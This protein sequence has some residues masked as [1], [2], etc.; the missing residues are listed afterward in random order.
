MEVPRRVLQ[1]LLTGLVLLGLAGALAA[2]ENGLRDLYYADCEVGRYG[3]REPAPGAN[4]T[5]DGE[6]TGDVLGPAELA[7]CQAERRTLTAIDAVQRASLGP[8]VSLVALV[9]AYV[10]AAAIA[11]R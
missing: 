2:V 11:R 6:K 1:G 10:L 8:G 5:Q 7:S 3:P 9:G 4:A